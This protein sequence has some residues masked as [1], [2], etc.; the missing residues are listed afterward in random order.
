MKLNRDAGLLLVGMLS[1]DQFVD[2]VVFKSII[3][4]SMFSV[5]QDECAVPVTGLGLLLTAV[6]FEFGVEIQH[7]FHM[8]LRQLRQRHAVFT[9]I[10]RAL[11][12]SLML[13]AVAKQAGEALGMINVMKSGA[14][15]KSGKKLADTSSASLWHAV[16]NLPND[17]GQELL[18][19]LKAEIEFFTASLWENTLLV[20]VGMTLLDST[21][22][23]VFRRELLGLFERELEAVFTT[24][25]VSATFLSGGQV[26]QQ[27]QK[28]AAIASASKNV[29]GKPSLI[30]SFTPLDL[31]V[32]DKLLAMPRTVKL[33]VQK[34][35]TELGLSPGVQFVR[36]CAHMWTNLC[37]PGHTVSVIAGPLACGKTSVLQTALHIIGSVGTAPALLL[38]AN[39]RCMTVWRAATIIK[40][41]V[42]AWL[43]SAPRLNSRG[44]RSEKGSQNGVR[45]KIAV[46]TSIIHHASVPAMYLLGCYDS[47]GTWMDGL[48]LRAIRKAD[49]I[50]G[51]DGQQHWHVIVLDGPC[52]PFVEQLFG[53]SYYQPHSRPVSLNDRISGHVSMPTGE[54]DLLASNIK[55]VMETGDLSHASPALVSQLPLMHLETDADTSV[56]RLVAVW[57]KSLCHWLDHIPPWTDVLA[58]IGRWLV[59]SRLIQ[60]CLYHDIS[61]HEMPT[62]V[63]ISRIGTFLRCFEELLVQCHELA[64]VESVFVDLDHLEGNSGTSGAELSAATEQQGVG[65]ENGNPSE[66]L[67]DGIS[68][69]QTKVMTLGPKGRIKLM[70]RAQLAIGYAAVWGFGGSGNTS[71]KRRLFDS[72]VRDNLYIYVTRGGSEIIIPEDFSVFEVIIN[73]EKLTMEHAADI[74]PRGV[75]KHCFGVSDRYHD[76]HVSAEVN[77]TGNLVFNTPNTRS[78]MNALRLLHSSGANP[79]LLGPRGCGKSFIVS[80]ML[81][82]R[83]RNVPST[84]AQVRLDTLKNLV[85]IVA[86]YEIKSRK[87]HPGNENKLDDIEKG[88][89]SAVVEACTSA[90]RRLEYLTKKSA[91]TDAAVGASMSDIQLCWQAVRDACKVLLLF[92]RFL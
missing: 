55:I 50:N 28:A 80:R 5:I 37:D 84:P 18:R 13:R 75:V 56:Q 76:Y 6:G 54:I 11:S 2:S 88:T 44:K 23:E 31:V 89:I 29:Q 82:D 42:M 26:S 66:S 81:L 78:V 9:N 65:C 41:T 24:S 19:R 17:S 1:E 58:E 33:I 63:A 32:G 7:I 71:D 74:S 52:G 45:S 90:L 61:I 40:R 60:S 86:N 69:Q 47:K 10:V 43:K 3:R 46:H 39:S 73:W 53:A 59:D 36:Q 87:A 62:A 85:R 35:A 22:W 30:S 67:Q 51:H 68:N 38:H 16:G 34:S 27:R 15:A 83:S 8:T 57:Y 20:S 14:V 21:S 92:L 64:V 25:N 48:L 70:R 72:I 79:L 4:G 91:G 77:S 49:A 12:S